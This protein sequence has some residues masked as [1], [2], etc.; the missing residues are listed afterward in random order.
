M[1]KHAIMTL[2]IDGADKDYNKSVLS[3][4]KYCQKYDIDFHLILE[5][6]VNGPNIFFEKF[7]FVHLLNDYEQVCYTD[8]DVLVTPHAQNIFE[9]YN[10]KNYFY[11][12]EE[13]RNL[14][15][16]CRQDFVEPLLPHCETWPLN[17]LNKYKY[18][19]AGVF[20]VSHLHKKYFEDY[21]NIPNIDNI[22][23]FGDQTYLNYLV[24]KSKIPYKEMDISYNK[25]HMGLPDPENKR[26]EANII[27]YAGQENK[28][29]I[30]EADYKHFYETI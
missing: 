21:K 12:F 6:T 10:D 17:H 5:R 29:S 9:E 13:N 14:D 27:H 18:F 1:K 15:K 24:V 26:Y 22:L 25:I 30:I 23:S 2:G 11:A 3:L 4:K 7:N 20:L 8:I 19:N 28:I 16:M